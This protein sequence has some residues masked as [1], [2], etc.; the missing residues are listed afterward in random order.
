M[1]LVIVSGELLG[2]LLELETQLQRTPGETLLF[3]S[4]HKLINYIIAHVAR[5]QRRRPWPQGDNL[6]NPASAMCKTIA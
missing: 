3:S 5:Q 2:N 1:E 4:I 6:P